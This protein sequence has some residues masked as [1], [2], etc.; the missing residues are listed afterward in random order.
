MFRRSAGR[1]DQPLRMLRI[2]DQE[3]DKEIRRGTHHRIILPEKSL[4]LCILIMLPD[5]MAKPRP[6]RRPDTVIRSI[7]GSRTPPRIGVVMEGPTPGT[8][9]VFSRSLA[10]FRKLF[11]QPEQGR[12]TRG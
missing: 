1:T 11:D 7:D 10:G 9:I 6:A 4:V 5:L 2:G 12:R 3:I 8:I